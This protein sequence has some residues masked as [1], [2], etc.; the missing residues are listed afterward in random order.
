MNPQDFWHA[1]AQKRYHDYAQ[2]STK[3]LADPLPIDTWVK[4]G[5]EIEWRGI[6][7][8]VLETPGFT[9]GSV[10]YIAPGLSPVD[11]RRYGWGKPG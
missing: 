6:S 7:F 8:Q 11:S 1:F 4:E 5:D 10:T 3:I 9:R 2:Q